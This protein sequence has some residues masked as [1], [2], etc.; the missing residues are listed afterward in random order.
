MVELKDNPW[1]L[2]LSE[3]LLGDLSFFLFVTY[4]II[5]YLIY[6]GC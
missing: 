1:T 6:L 4:L 2:A 5:F 3:I